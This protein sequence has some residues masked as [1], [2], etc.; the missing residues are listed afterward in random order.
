LIFT[1]QSYEK[2]FNYANILATFLGEI[3]KK[4]SIEFLA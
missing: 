4:I 2:D 3:A 1:P